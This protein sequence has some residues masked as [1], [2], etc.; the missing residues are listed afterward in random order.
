MITEEVIPERNNSLDVISGILIIWMLFYHVFQKSGM[1]SSPIYVYALRCLY[2][3]LP[4]FFYKSGMFH[5]EMPPG[6]VFVRQGK[7][8]IGPFVLFTLIGEFVFSF[9][10]FGS[11]DRQ[12]IHYVLTPCKNILLGGASRGNMPLWFLSALFLVKFLI[13]LWERLKFPKLLLGI[14]SLIFV[15]GVQFFPGV[16]Q[17]IPTILQCTFLGV[18]FYLCGYY[19]REWQ[20]KKAVL[21][22]GAAA[23][24]LT[25]VFVPSYVDFR[26]NSTLSGYWILWV[27]ASIGAI[28]AINNLFRLKFLCPGI[29]AW[30][31]RHS[32]FLLCTHWIILNLVI[33]LLRGLPVCEPSGWALFGCM[34]SALFV[35]YLIYGLIV[36]LRLLPID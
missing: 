21:S 36:C 18:F 20:Y 25:A 10:L 6:Q 17:M 24:L 32:M 27:V 13:S 35:I 23:A 26:I 8:L 30:I 31:G 28:I 33:L 11:G 22:A 4:W 7:K 14:L 12:W 19:L 2:F 3:F 5:K 34:A 29:L 1:T 15:G 16:Y 9:I